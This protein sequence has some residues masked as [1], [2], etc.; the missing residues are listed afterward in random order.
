MR[1]FVW[2]VVLALALPLGASVLRADDEPAA[3]AVSPEMQARIAKLIEQLGADDFRAREAASRELE[4]LGAEAKEA[5]AKAVRTSESPEVRWRAEQL[6]RRLEGSGEKPL[7]GDREARGPGAPRGEPRDPFAEA[8]RLIEEWTKGMKKLGEEPWAAPFG[9]LPWGPLSGPRRVEVPGLVLERTG[10]GQMQL[11]AKRK[12]D[13]GEEIEDVYEGHSLRDI[14][15]RH[16]ELERLPGMDELKR[17]EA[18]RSWPGFEDF[19][20]RRLPHI[21]VEPFAGGG[22][23]GFS[24]STSQG[25]EVTQ[26]ADG[27]TVRLREKDENG[28]EQVKEY[29]GES[30]EQLKRDHPELREKLKGFGF[31]LRFGPPEIIWPG[32]Q[33]DRLRPR[34][35]TT[36][37]PEAPRP[38]AP[39][40]RFGLTV[41]E[42]DEALASHLGLAEGM[43]ALVVAVEPGS[44]AAQLGVQRNDILVRIDGVE[45]GFDTAAE[46]LRKAA[47]SKAPLSVH[48]VRRGA[49]LTLSR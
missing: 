30:L 9:P 13:G 18:E 19:L 36:P 29:K 17:K 21:R 45:V 44:Q 41:V 5:L 22:G 31:Q 20:E 48:I 40:A 49:N 38:E 28:E 8:R 11:R 12:T 15:H 32:R 7:G 24:F 34:A 14:L 25:I 23:S 43:G 1:T 16:P 33:R 27:V 3:P 42:V 26:G 6:L 2:I 35:P 47:A 39:Q 4:G 37:R 46:R 10:P